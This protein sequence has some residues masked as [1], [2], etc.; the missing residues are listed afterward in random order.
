[1]TEKPDAFLITD[2]ELCFG[3]F[4]CGIP[5]YYSAFI[6]NTMADDDIPII[7]LWKDDFSVDH[8]KERKN[9]NEGFLGFI[10]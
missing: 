6:E 5:V 2:N 10:K 9:F 7:P 8:A 1:M 4:I 3:D